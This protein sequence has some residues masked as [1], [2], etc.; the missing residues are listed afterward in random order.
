MPT[1]QKLSTS[2]ATA[3]LKQNIKSSMSEELFDDV[4]ASS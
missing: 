3:A 2:L 1:S 4:I